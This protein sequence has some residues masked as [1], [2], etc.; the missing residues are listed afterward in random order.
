MAKASPPVKYRSDPSLL[1]VVLT[2]SLVWGCKA[3]RKGTLMC[4]GVACEQILG[5]LAILHC[6]ARNAWVVAVLQCHN[7][8]AAVCQPH[9]LLHPP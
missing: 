6:P 4:M 8:K 7:L 9:R 1:V 5:L 2:P 3:T